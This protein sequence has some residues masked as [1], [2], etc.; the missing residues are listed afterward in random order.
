[1]KKIKSLLLILT[2][3][4]CSVGV[5]SIKAKEKVSVYLFY[6][7]G[8]GYCAN[9]KE[10]F[11]SIESTYG[12]KFELI[13]KEVWSNEEN[14][15]LMHE[16]ASKLGDTVEGVPYI[17]IGKKSFPGY[18]TSFDDQ[19]KKAI[20]EEYNAKE[21]YD[22]LSSVATNVA[23]KDKTNNLPIYFSIFVIAAGIIGLVFYA[24]KSV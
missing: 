4:L 5:N 7:E 2:L 16:I 1:M 13:K 12:E 14:S 24:K 18:N 19:I 10:F 3:L 23:K 17:V 9:A 6:G 22:A 11:A 15:K 20:D 21:K 8:C